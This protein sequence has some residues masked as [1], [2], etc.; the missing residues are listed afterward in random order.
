MHGSENIAV[1]VFRLGVRDYLT[2]PFTVEEVRVAVD[3]ALREERLAKE[4][5]ALAR[6]LAS[7]DTV[8]QTVITL[9]HYINNSLMVVEGGLNLVEEG[10]KKQESDFNLWQQVIHDSLDS[11]HKIKAVMRVLQRVTGLD[12]ATYHGNIRMIDIE[13]A[14]QEELDKTD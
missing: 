1:E 13:K 2:K 6:Q 5:E 12:D 3:R 14:L 8:R 7:A 10:V 9:S 11:A 4:K